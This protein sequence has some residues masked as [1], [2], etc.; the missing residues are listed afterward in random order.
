MTG[1]DLLCVCECVGV[2][3]RADTQCAVCGRRPG[4]TGQSGSEG[5]S[6]TEGTFPLSRL[7]RMRQHEQRTLTERERGREGG[8]ERERGRERDHTKTQNER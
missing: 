3:G 7:R 2:C 4:P 5:L 1:S 8:Q 6:G